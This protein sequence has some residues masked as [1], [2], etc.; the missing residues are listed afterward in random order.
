MRR[1]K[2]WSVF[3]VLAVLFT[4]LVALTIGA[5]GATGQE[6]RKVVPQGSDLECGTCPTRTPTR[7]PYR[8]R[9]ATAT[10]TRTPTWPPPTRTVTPSRT[11]TWPPSTRTATPKFTPTYPP[12]ETPFPTFTPTPGPECGDWCNPFYYVGGRYLIEEISPSPLEI[13]ILLPSGH[14][15]VREVPPVSVLY[16]YWI[17]LKLVKKAVPL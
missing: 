8:T 14:A 6:P 11:P 10:P 15:Y 4:V 3:T 2:S 5:P 13:E 9:T 1:H 7:T 16:L 17:D 12:A